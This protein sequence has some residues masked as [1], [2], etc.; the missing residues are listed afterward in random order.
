MTNTSLFFSIN[1]LAGHSVWLDRL[2]IFFADY[3]GY[4]IL[5]ILVLILFSRPSVAARRMVVVASVS[6][7]ISRGIVTTA[8]RFLYYHSRPFTAL[9]VNQLIPES[10]ASF[11]SGHAAFYFAIAMAVYLYNKKLGISFFVISLLM[12]LARIYAGVHWPADVVGGLVVGVVT[13]LLIDFFIRKF[14]EKTKLPIGEFIT[15]DLVS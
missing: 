11:P 3:S 9:H 12:G 15:K 1:N 2:G 8:I 5:A 4:I 14:V 13:A 6:A 7:I 10:G